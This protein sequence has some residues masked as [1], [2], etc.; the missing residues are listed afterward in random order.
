M[1]LRHLS[2]TNFRNFT[3]LET[4]FP[5]GITLLMGDNAQGKTSL[6]EAIYYLT[7][8][9]SPHASN[10]RQLIN[11]LA[12]QDESPFAKLN[13]EIEREGDLRRVEIRLILENA[14][15]ETRLR[16]EVLINGIKR[17]VGDLP[18]EFNAVLFLPQDMH[19]LEGSPSLRRR[20]LDDAIS[21]A[22]PRYSQT[23]RRFGRVLT[24]R[25]A[26]LKQIQDGS[27]SADQLGFWDQK[28][29]ELA[30][31]LMRA[32]AVGLHELESQ[33]VEIHAD[34]TRGR[35][36]LRIRYTPAFHPGDHPGGQLGL[37]MEGAFDW[38]GM[39]REAMRQG[40]LDTFLRSRAQ[41]I[42]RGMTL[43]GPHR[44][45][46]GFIS[47]GIDLHTFGSRGQ[48]RTAMLALKL[49]EVEWLREKT[50]RWP[51]LL[52]DEVLAELDVQ[53]R[54][55]LLARVAKAQQALLTTTDLEMIAPRYRDGTPIWR[56][57][58]GTIRVE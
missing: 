55:D 9:S 36:T 41:E 35:E 56:I 52:L 43:T 3:R 31:D 34:L 4:T 58:R 45:D 14:V 50:G 28:L 33:A 1:Q 7:S 19:V 39:S 30:A 24:Q 38:V 6:L 10:E 46:F 12:M 23:L 57:R 5:A 2:L 54:E 21:Q 37:P 17:R 51:V 26:L 47:N 13:A 42:G 53:R 49:A 48:N 20:Y 40:L 27:G 8:A 25:N 16:K 29:S 11:M 32:R 18:G 22:D 44:D 15:G